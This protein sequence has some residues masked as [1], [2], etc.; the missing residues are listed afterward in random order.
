MVRLLATDAK[1]F[2]A[3]REHRYLRALTQEG[4]CQRGAAV[5]QVLAVIEQQQ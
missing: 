2:S 1:R 4:I 3:T 5:E